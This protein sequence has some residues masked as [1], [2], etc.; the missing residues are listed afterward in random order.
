MSGSTHSVAGFRASF[1]GIVLVEG[2][3]GYDTARALWNGD[4]D[5]KPAVIA[6][7]TTAEHV[8]AAVAYGR[9]EGLEIAVRGGGHNFAGH[10]V[11]EGGLM[12][13]LSGMTDVVVD[14]AAKRARCGGGTTWAMLDGACQ[15]HGLAVPGGVVSHTGVAG[16]SLGGGIGWLSRRHGL[17]CD[18]LVS[19]RVVTADGRIVTASANEDPDLYWALRGGGGN[20]GVVTEFEFQLHDVG[21]IVQAALMFVPSDRGAAGVRSMRDALATLPDDYGRQ[22]V[23]LNAPPMP[24]VPEALHF[25]PGYIVAVIGWGTPEEH[26]AAI[27]PVR[28]G[29]D[30]AFELVTPIPY[31]D[32]QQFIDASSPWGILG[33]ERAIYLDELTDDAAAVVAEHFARKASPMSIMPVFMLGGAYA[34]VPEGDTAFG[35]SRSAKWLF[36]IAA[37]APDPALL[38][39]DR[40]WVRDF[41]DALLPY[42]SGSGSYVNFIADAGDQDRVRASYGPDKY[43][44]LARIKAEWDPDNVFHLNANIRPIEKV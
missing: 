11:C 3:D 26:A 9:A 15:E 36:N 28:D 21:P 33:Y 29:L 6:Q 22:I 34:R 30:P 27:G 1:D 18:N 14:P 42:A 37:V 19:A 4:I 39:Q 8:V 2:N 20:F 31:T 17:S 16:L 24:F 23:G 43:E 41:W 35:G 44:R 5:R 13:D 12:I 7:C 25:A 10:G 32:L 40:Q 38:A